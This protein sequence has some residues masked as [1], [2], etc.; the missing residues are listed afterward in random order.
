MR[1]AIRISRN[2]SRNRGLG[3]GAFPFI[4]QGTFFE[5]PVLMGFIAG[6]TALLVPGEGVSA[7]RI[8]AYFD[9]N[10]ALILAVWIV[11]V[12]ATARMARRRPWD[13]AMVAVAPGMIL[14]GTINWDMW[15]VGLLALG[16]YC[17]SRNKLVLAGIFIGLGTATKLYPV[18][19]L[20]AVLLLALRT[21]RIRGVL[22]TAGAA[23]AAWLA[24]NLPVAAVNPEGWKYFYDFTEDRPAGYS[25]PWFA[26]NLV[27]GR[28][29]LL[30]LQPEAI[31]TLAMNL[32]VLACVLIGGIGPDR[33]PAAPARA[34]HL[35]DR[36]RVH[37]DQQGLLT[38]V[39]HL[40][41]PAACPRPAALAGF[42]DLAD[43]RGAAL[44]GG[45]DVSRA[46]DERRGLPAQY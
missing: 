14:A 23:A 37:P 29:G 11:T 28:L 42:P 7:T 39:R 25:S 16:M 45:L 21:G 27:A 32:F 24:V 36:R 41:H 6:A 9:I 44:G 43:L 34:A 4:T 35:P 26:Y 20:G 22:V 17:F 19:I 31:N 46:G 1:P 8:L 38:P 15:A 13:A 12:L 3:D 5:Y 40:A 2:C 10:A 18:L 33:A 30:P